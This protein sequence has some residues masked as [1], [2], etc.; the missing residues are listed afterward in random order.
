MSWLA[1]DYPQE[2]K[3]EQLFYRDHC[4]IGFKFK[5]SNLHRTFNIPEPEVGVAEDASIGAMKLD[6]T[7]EY[8]FALSLENRAFLFRHRREW[9]TPP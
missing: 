3:N 5:Q 8:V 7:M 9:L 1:C 4:R 6:C 2:V